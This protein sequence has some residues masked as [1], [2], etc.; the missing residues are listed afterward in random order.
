[1]IIHPKPWF[2]TPYYKTPIPQIPPLKPF[3]ANHVLGSIPL[4]LIK[5]KR[6]GSVMSKP[7]MKLLTG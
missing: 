4:Y 3:V 7:K 1:M 5:I 6:K 2:L